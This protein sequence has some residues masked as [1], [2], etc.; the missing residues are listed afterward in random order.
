MSDRAWEELLDLIDEKFGIDSLQTQ[1]QPLADN[2]ELSETV[3]TVSFERSGQAYR[4]VRTIRPRVIDK[5]S[6]FHRTG[7]AQR[8]ENVYDPD[9]TTAFVSFYK[10]QGSDW[11]EISP[12]SFL[13]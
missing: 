12:E 8:V 5:K 6:Y 2:P 1:K 10:K 11:Q 13:N 7:G 4:F 3:V 9:E